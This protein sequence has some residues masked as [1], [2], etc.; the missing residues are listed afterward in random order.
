[1]RRKAQMALRLKTEMYN[2]VVELAEEQETSASAIVRI[3]IKEYL[4]THK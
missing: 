3:A 2:D 4:R 1:M